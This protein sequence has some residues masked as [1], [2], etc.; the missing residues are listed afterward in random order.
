[1]KLY[2]ETDG[3]DTA[4]TAKL[5]EVTPEG[6]AYHIRSSITTIGA[7]LPE[8]ERYQPGSTVEVS[9]DMWDIAYT[10]GK[11]S[12]IRVDI[13][14]SD[15]PLYNIHSNYAGLWSVQTKV[16]TA[17]QTVRMGADCLSCVILPLENGGAVI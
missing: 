14:S 10:I 8:G 4:F 16:R 9:V 17:K 2:V 1:M 5:M 6:R 3:E 15:F 12:R 13:S 7:E 11:G